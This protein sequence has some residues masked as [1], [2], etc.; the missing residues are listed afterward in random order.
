MVR[1]GRRHFD[2]VVL[3]WR[4]VDVFGGFLERRM[5]EVLVRMMGVVEVLWKGFVDVVSGDNTS[6]RILCVV[7]CSR[8]P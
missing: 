4:F 8:P 3:R 5:R 6:D 7:C 2:C 1:L